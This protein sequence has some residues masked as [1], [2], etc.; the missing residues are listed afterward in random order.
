M[1]TVGGVVAALLIGD[2]SYHRRQIQHGLRQDRL[3]EQAYLSEA[4]REAGVR[5]QVRHLIGCGQGT[6]GRRPQEPPLSG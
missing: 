6:G 5:V 4:E 1:R 2:Q 3:Q